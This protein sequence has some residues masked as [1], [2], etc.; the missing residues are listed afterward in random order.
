[1]VM[2]PVAFVAGGLLFGRSLMARG[3]FRYSLPGGAALPS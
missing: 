3:R 1:M 2:V